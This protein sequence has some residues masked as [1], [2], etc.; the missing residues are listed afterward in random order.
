M[1]FFSC[2][3]SDLGNYLRTLITWTKTSGER[4]FSLKDALFHLWHLAYI[5]HFLPLIRAH[6]AA[7]AERGAGSNSRYHDNLI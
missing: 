5:Y 3:I 4:S 7:A 2:Y 6:R 1:V